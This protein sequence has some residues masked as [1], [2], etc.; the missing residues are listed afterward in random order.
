MRVLFLIFANIVVLVSC[1]SLKKLPLEKQS[2]K[3]PVFDLAWSKNLDPEHETGNLPIGMGSPLIVD[4]MLFM[5]SLDGHMRAFDIQ[6]GRMLWDENDGQ[7]IAAKPT[8]YQD[9]IIYGTRMGRLAAR[10]YLTGE[11]KYSIDL[12]APIES[13]PMVAEG[14]MFVHLRNHQLITLDAITGK[15]FWSYKRSV[16]YSSTLQRVSRPII[17]EG[18][19]LIGFADGYVGALSLEEGVMLWDRKITN[20]HKFIDVD[21]MPLIYHGKI[22]AG[23]A[24]GPLVF[25]Q[26]DNG[27]I[28]RT[29]EITIGH[30][31]LVVDGDLLVG[32]VRGELVRLDKDG[33]ILSQVKVSDNSISSLGLWKDG[34]A[35]STMGQ[36]LYFVRMSDFKIQDQFLL[37]SDFSSVFGSLQESKGHLAVYSSRNRLYV[38]R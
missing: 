35:I 34:I 27:L 12:G 38:F 30:T 28:I 6:S 19:I 16:P 18:K 23:S 11:L 17:Y 31:P 24:N 15:V 21:V 36:E 22:V 33:Q 7:S 10:H 1:S 29:I 3:R 5:G 25:M 14:R 32:T 13:E 9:H 8:F 20:N 26:P 2:L 37:G 4:G